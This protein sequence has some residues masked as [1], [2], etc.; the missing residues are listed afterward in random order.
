MKY[1]IAPTWRGYEISTTQNGRI[2]YLQSIYKGT[3]KWTL[4]YLYSRKYATEAAA[5]KAI[6]AIKDV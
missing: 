2:V 5:C 3:A 6:K 1:T 4:D